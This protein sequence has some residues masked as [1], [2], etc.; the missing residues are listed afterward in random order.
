MK[1]FLIAACVAAATFCSPAA[2]RADAPASPAPAASAPL[3]HLVYSFQYGSTQSI[4]A[5]D[6]SETPMQADVDTGQLVAGA[7]GVSH[8]GG[9]LGD[10]GTMTVDVLAER[11]DKGLVVSISEQGE[12]TRKAPP[13]TCIVYGD[14]RVMCDPNKTVNPE[15]YTLMRFLASN[16]ID[17]DKVDANQHWE[18]AQTSGN[19]T[20]KADYTIKSIQ[21]G[22]M[23]I[24]ETRSIK[25]TG[26]SRQTT[27][28]QSK[29]TYNG[30][31][32]VPTSIDE[33]VTQRLEGGV[34][35]N[36][37]TIYQT[38]LKLQSDSMKKPASAPQ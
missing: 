14:T 13:A 38:L 11:P 27:D 37:T 35:G 24:D 3:R 10:K 21:D 36:A 22:M 19:F 5:R 4:S 17:P 34:S 8:Y 23:A 31:L 6:N 7:S 25:T 16:F 18:V 32:L 29:I 2:A 12:V 30:P 20:S 9:S 28:V 33:Y 26:N 1:P 15:E